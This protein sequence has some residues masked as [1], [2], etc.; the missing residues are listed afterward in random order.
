MNRRN[1]TLLVVGIAVT[2]ALLA[3]VGVYRAVLRAAAAPKITGRHQV[4]VATTPLQLGRMLDRLDLKVV[5]WPDDVTIAG[6]F[7]SVDAVVG[8]GVIAPFV[9][10]EPIVAAKLAPAEGGAGLPPAIPPGMRAMAVKTNEVI[11]VAGFAVPGTRV[12]VVAT[13]R[14]GKEDVSHVVLSNVRVLTVGT[15]PDQTKN[16]EPV[17]AT[18]VTLL[19]TP[20]EAERLALAMNEGRISLALRNPLD[21]SVTQTPGVRMSNLVTAERTAPAPSKTPGPPKAAIAPPPPAAPA[22]LPYVVQV[23]RA[24]KKTDETVK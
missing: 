23:I 14:S 5:S 24:A 2:L 8:R 19:V 4:V 3:S 13:V 9:P 6:T 12:D 7:E 22:S 10:N 18:V 16:N 20:V 17:R 11:G 1:R 15:S 21:L